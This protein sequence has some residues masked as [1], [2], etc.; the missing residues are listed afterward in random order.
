MTHIEAW[1]FLVSR[2]QFLDYR[3]VVAPVF[4]CELN[5]TSMLAKAAEGDLTEGN[6]AWYREV[7]GSKAGDLTLVFRVIKATSEDTGIQIEA[8]SDNLEV[9]RSGLLKDS[10]GREIQLIEGI[11][12]K[13]IGAEVRITQRSF[14]QI[15]PQLIE[16]YQEFWKYTTSQ[17]VI[18]SDL[19]YLNNE[20][21]ELE[22]KVLK[23]YVLEIRKQAPK[24]E[25]SPEILVSQS[26]STQSW[27]NNGKLSLPFPNEVASISC[28]FDGS[29][30]AF[31]CNREIAVTNLNN[32]KKIIYLNPAQKGLADFPS[33]IVV[34]RD[35]MLLA[36]GM[37]EIPDENVVKVWKIS[38]KEVISFHGHSWS[39]QG[40]IRA[41]GITS[42][43]EV[44]LSGSDD[45]IIRIWDI[46]SK[47][48]LG[49]FSEHSTSVR[50]I[51][52]RQDNLTIISGDGKGV[53]KFWNWQNQRTIHNIK[54][55]SLPINSLAIS[56]DDSLIA[57]A[58]DNQEIK[59]WNAKNGQA[60]FTLREHSA[61]INSIAFSSDSKL[62]A[63]GDDNGCIQIWDIELQK[64]VSVL[65][66]HCKSVTSLAFTSND[67]D[68][69]LVSA[70]KDRTIKMWRQVRG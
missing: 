7:H 3:T 30:L 38:S 31:R 53:I 1:S 20:G 62:L 52:L 9:Y 43:N 10:F 28:S 21:I 40:R 70:S 58:G 27:E 55:H 36:T 42:D 26:V 35:N 61:P 57:S 12:L 14:E 24:T 64:A 33:P 47:G 17:P 15:H 60:L 65:S 23:P 66:K 46:K 63:S 39:Q 44:V 34:S 67:N 50:A 29:F 48:E 69:I 41:I 2:N 49:T 54:A 6:S 13:G 45:G 68:L 16:K 4:M 51:V 56:P 5:V 19:F 25:K 18:P 37:I 8:I 11:V 59:L 32:T 22:L